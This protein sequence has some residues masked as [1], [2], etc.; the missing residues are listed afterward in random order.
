LTCSCGVAPNRTLAKICSDKNKPNGQYVLESTKQAVE[1]FV[2][3]LPVRKVPGVGRVT[4]HCLKAFGIEKCGDIVQ[5]R[6]LLAALFSPISMEFFL[7]CALGLGSTQHGDTVGEG[8]VGRKGISTERT[9]R[10]MSQ[11]SE[12]EAKCKELAENLAAD[13]AEENLKGKTLTLKLK[14]TTFEVRTRAVTLPKYVSSAEDILA[15][16]LKLLRAE[17]PVEI[18][19]MGLRMSHFY[20]EPK[21]ERDQPSLQDVFSRREKR[22]KEKK[23]K[24]DSKINEEADE[25]DIM[26]HTSQVLSAGDEVELT[27]RDWQDP[28]S[29][30][31]AAAAGA[32]SGAAGAVPGPVKQPIKEQTWACVQC[33]FENPKRELLCLMCGCSKTGTR[34]GDDGQQHR[35]KKRSGGAA[36]AGGSSILDFCVPQKTQKKE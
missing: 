35:G 33:T 32:A 18:R 14:L 30:T 29:S 20:E 3:E 6:G 4:E 21:R 12:L 5:H 15:A 27:L 24:D 9:F 10:A 31:G 28:S 17:L 8:E 11:R 36:A 16:G 23:E 22:I 26:V 25:G 2:Q 19:L 13:M 7:H 1:A 34:P